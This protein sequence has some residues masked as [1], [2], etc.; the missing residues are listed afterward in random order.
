MGKVI[1]WL[2]RKVLAERDYWINESIKRGQRIVAIEDELA[3]ATLR[4]VSAESKLANMQKPV[5]LEPTT[6]KVST[7]A[8]VR[9]IMADQARRDMEDQDGIR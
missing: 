6:I 1:D 3:A 5:P 8:D 7:A 2:A 4:A 9:R